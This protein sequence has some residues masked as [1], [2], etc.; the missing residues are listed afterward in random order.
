MFLKNFNGPIPQYK[1]GR[2][3]LNLTK[4]CSWDTGEKT[5][6][7]NNDKLLRLSSV[8]SKLKTLSWTNI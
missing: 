4:E 7:K 5:C 2:L 3:P 6:K 1:W 8:S